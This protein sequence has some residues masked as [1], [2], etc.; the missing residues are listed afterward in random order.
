M[1]STFCLGENEM[2]HPQKEFF[3]LVFQGDLRKFKAN[4]HMTDTPFGRAVASGVGDAFAEIDDL[5]D[6]L[7]QLTKSENRT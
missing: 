5:T 4:P 1:S 3:T 6:Q 7:N 2:T